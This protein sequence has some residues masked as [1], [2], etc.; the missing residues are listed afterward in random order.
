MQTLLLL[1]AI[2]GQPAMAS[3]QD[4]A[5]NRPVTKV[6]NLL[7]D[8]I[9]Q[10]E[11]EGEEDEE[12]FEKMG[13]WCVTNEKAK[14]KSVADA[15][16]AISDYSTAIEQLT[17]TSA[18][19]NAEIGNLEKELAKNTEGLESATAMREKELAAFN[20]EE[21]ETISTVGALKGAVIA[22]SKH[23]SSFLQEGTGAST[24]QSIE[25]WAN[26]KTRL[27]KQA[28]VIEGV[29]TPHD[30]KK[31][32]AFVQEAEKR[33]RYEPA[34]GEIFGILKQMKESFET[35]LA[36]SQKEE[37]QAQTDYEDVKTAKE[38]EIAAATDLI[39]K[40]SAELAAADEKNAQSKES[41]EDNRNVLA[42]DTKFLGELKMQCQNID[43]EY[44]ERVKTRQA[45]I[46]A[47]S[48]ALAF[49]SSDEAHDLFSRTLGFIQTGST[50]NSKNRIEVSKALKKVAQKFHDS[51]VAALAYS[52]RLDA[53]TEVK[54]AIQE[55]VDKLIKEKADE[56]KHKD[57]CI[58]ELNTNEKDQDNKVRDK[59]DLKAEID[60][61][62]MSIDT[63]VKD[64]ETLKAE[65]TEL[66]VQMKAA[67]E[68]RE[69]ENK[70]FQVV[71][72][73][74]RAT[75]KLLA[76]AL[77]I[78]KGFYDKAALI[79]KRASSASDQP[80]PP[81]FKKMESS[82][83]SGGVMGM[84]EGIIKEAKAME[85]EALHGEETAQT[86]YEE[87]VKDTNEAVETKE[88][89]I[90][91]KMDMKAKA[92]SDQVQATASQEAVMGEIE[93]LENESADLHKSCD[94]ILKNFDVRQAARDDEIDA[95]KQALAMFSGASFSAFLQD[96]Q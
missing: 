86:A 64:I 89:D 3:V 53:F 35:N 38:G 80:A 1:L 79:Q 32:F 25:M 72:A 65:V 68:S 91:S 49:L 85:A 7:K 90:T 23:H 12:V 31:V 18:K 73:D 24:L 75:Q 70:E 39:D 96:P 15:E 17:A 81:G 19:L 92:E 95:L 6:I 44:E 48:K 21:K 59:G 63:L 93:Q 16:Q 43:Q 2:L 40:K 45:E 27:H 74:Q 52:A 69:K 20:A 13:C 47:C 61:L 84:M 87:F 71:V 33:G 41:L 66:G 29:I 5:K 8:M 76:A 51:D 46:Q 67:S 9:K 55:M 34:S 82:A 54:K 28:S 62:G 50:Q 77:E 22:L 78:L 30:K 94:F 36:N 10:M 42:A 37:M 57:W 14:T 60:D 4:E 56:I 58:D 83:A 88:T 11:K 26:L